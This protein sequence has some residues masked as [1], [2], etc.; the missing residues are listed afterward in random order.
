M[1]RPARKG[2]IGPD[3]KLIAY[4]A[5]KGLQRYPAVKP[6][7]D[8]HIRNEG[9]RVIMREGG[10]RAI[11]DLFIA[12]VNYMFNEYDDG[13][14]RMNNRL[15]ADGNG[16]RISASFLSM[17]KTGKR[18]VFSTVLLTVFSWYFKKYHVVSIEPYEWIAY[19]FEMAGSYKNLLKEN[20]VKK[21]K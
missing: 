13:T 9:L 21:R 17:L 16:F 5:A 4:I 8:I 10:H 14:V 11:K 15:K 1:G 7:G 3:G 2:V 18:N 12:N 20:K 6:I 19:D